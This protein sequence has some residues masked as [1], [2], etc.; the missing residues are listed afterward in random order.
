MES[1]IKKIV[2]FIIEKY[3]VFTKFYVQTELNPR[4]YYIDG[5]RNKE[6]NI[7]LITDYDVYDKAYV[8]WDK[9]VDEI[10]RK[11]TRLNSSH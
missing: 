1:V 4:S 8:D 3:P 6:Y 2:A 7:I 5:N 11:S 10:D 9:V